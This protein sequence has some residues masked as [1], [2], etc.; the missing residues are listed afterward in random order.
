MM[1]PVKREI[2]LTEDQCG[3]LIELLN[4]A[5]KRNRGHARNCLTGYGTVRSSSKHD[6]WME[7]AHEYEA[8]IETLREPWY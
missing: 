2:R 6:A 7:K 8:I 1:E 5:E 4:S 3:L